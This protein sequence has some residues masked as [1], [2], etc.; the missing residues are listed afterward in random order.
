MFPSIY[1]IT[2]EDYPLQLQQIEKLPKHLSVIGTI[3]GPEYKFLCVVG[4]RKYS[5]YGKSVCWRIINGLKGHPI[6]IVSGLAI[7]ID[8]IAHEA[9][10]ANNLKTIA[11]P[12]SGLDEQVIYPRQHLHL[13]RRI[14]ENGGAL[15]SSFPHDFKS[16]K[17]TFPVR[18][19]LMAAISH[20]TLIIEAVQGS[21]SLLTARDALEFGRDVMAVPGSVY[22]DYSFGPHMLMKNG[23]TPV[24][25]AKDVLEMLGCNTETLVT[26]TVDIESLALSPIEKQIV[27][28]L[29]IS[30]LSATELLDKTFLPISTFNMIA[31]QLE[32]QGIITQSGGMYRMNL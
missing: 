11:F 17:W 24:G 27:A 12:G 8:S 31:S 10:L 6:V 21:G 14:V 25:T 29:Q 28:E 13:A 7:G 9:A 26:Q 20:G 3:P 22:S 30:A 2:K 5:A 15:I 18:N 32:L 16:T 4:S 23:A 1:E 19:T